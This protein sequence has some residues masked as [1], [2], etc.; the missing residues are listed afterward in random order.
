[1]LEEGESEHHHQGVPM[2]PGPGAALEVVEAEFLLHLLMR[3]LADP[4]RLD[5][6]GQALQGGV[7]GQVGEVVL[8]FAGRAVF[9]NEPSR[10][11]GQVLLALV[12]NALWRTIGDAHAQGGEARPER[13]FGADAPAERRPF[14]L[15]QGALG[16]GDRM[17]GT[18]FLRGRPRRAFGKTSE[19]P[20]G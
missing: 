14:D 7:G 6:F 5:D 16:R 15:R 1:M 3:L 12:E 11:T 17:S 8:A 10:L 2:N 9:A 4:A 20:T 18:G 19:T 13:P